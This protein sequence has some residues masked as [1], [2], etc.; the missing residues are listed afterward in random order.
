[1]VE[2]IGSLRLSGSDS[3][4]VSGRS[5]VATSRNNREPGRFAARG[6]AYGEAS[7]RS[8]AANLLGQDRD[9]RLILSLAV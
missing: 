1:M 6:D 2:V 5:I 7:S 3:V 8:A 4:L 9:G